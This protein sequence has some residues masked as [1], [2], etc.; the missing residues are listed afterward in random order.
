MQI[1]LLTHETNVEESP[2]FPPY[3]GENPLRSLLYLYRSD[4]H[5]IAA[6]FGLYIVKHSPEWIRPLIFANVINIL[7][8]PAN[9]NLWDLW[10]N[11][12]ILAI[13]ILQNVPTHYLHIR[14]ISAA[15]R[16]IEY[17][18][19]QSL[20]RQLHNLEITYYFR[21][22]SGALQNKLLQ[23]VESIQ[24]LTFQLFQLLPGACLTLAIAIGVVAWRAPW[25][26]L[27]YLATIPLAVLLIFTFRK[28]IAQRNER[29]RQEFEQLAAY[30]IDAIRLI[31]IARAHGVQETALQESSQRLR[32]LRNAGM[33]VDRINAIA[34][35]AAWITLQL[36]DVICLVTAATLVYTGR[37]NIQ[38][39]DVILLTAY[40]DELTNSIVQI[41]TLLPE[42]G[43]GFAAIRSVAE[44]LKCS[45][46]ED[47]E[48]KYRLN[49]LRGFLVF[50]GVSFT[51]PGKNQPSLAHISFQVS[52]GETI[53]IVGP[54]G[55]G[56]ST[57]VN[58]VSGLL[59]PTE[60]Q[61]LVDGRDLQK[62]DL[63]SYR[64]FLAVV[65]Q[66]TILFQG[67]VKENILYGIDASDEMLH[68]AIAEAGATEFVAA[69]PEG[70]ETF[71]GENGIQLSGG[72][73][74]RIAIARALVRQPRILILDEAT[75][76][77]DMAAERSIQEAIEAMMGQR[78]IFLVAHRFSA[79][80]QVDRIIV[81]DNARLVEMGTY[82]ELLQR[83]GL[84]AKLNSLQQSI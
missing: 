8:Q 69:L 82:N 57:L 4:W 45:E 60:G 55:V 9:H 30:L 14:F 61:I 54:S 18:L 36:F 25:F 80:R 20:M 50:E 74:Q 31:P 43:R 66:E 33:K 64:R 44:V 46:R 6:S 48:G 75:A 84:F 70:L 11:G 22:S 32:R 19:R 42:M 29:L 52:P 76:S 5:N 23:D 21:Q 24:L 41:G 58:L 28:P 65:S 26:L 72:Q 63:R 17:H 81:L 39:G 49:K 67:S 73:R 59:R 16:N 78:T 79:L 35:G 34:N 51:Y 10:L 68:Q 7:S 56:K 62:L 40:F 53:G 71:I 15:S 37:G 3:F 12:F 83:Q 1:K 27:F 13:F 2:A 77:L 38:V 47:N